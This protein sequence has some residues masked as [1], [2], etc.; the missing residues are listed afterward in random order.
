MTSGGRV[1]LVRPPVFWVSI[2]V[3]ARQYPQVPSAEERGFT[4]LEIL[5]ALTI[6]AVVGLISAQLLSRT[7]DSYDVL[8]GAGGAFGANSPRNDDHAARSYAVP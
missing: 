5:V 2:D 8:E 3:A 7:V 1:R 4:L 6:F